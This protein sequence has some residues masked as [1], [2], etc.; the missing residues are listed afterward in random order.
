MEIS[1]S[2]FRVLG[3]GGILGSSGWGSR[4]QGFGSWGVEFLGSGA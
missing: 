2:G 4:I 3:G 1:D